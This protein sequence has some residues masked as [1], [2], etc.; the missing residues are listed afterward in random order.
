[1]NK[2]RIA[3]V[4]AS[5]AI[6]ALMAAGQMTAQAG[7]I[8]H[9]R[10]D[11]LYTS[12]AAS[13]AY[14][15]VGDMIINGDTRCSG[16]AISSTWILTAAHCVDGPISSLTFTVGSATYTGIDQIVHENWTTG[17]AAGWD[18]ALVRVGSAMSGITFASLYTGSDELGRVGT[19]VGFGRTGTGLTGSTLSSG[20]KRAGD[21]MI[22]VTGLAV[23]WS[24]NLLFQDFD[25][26]LNAGDSF[27]GLASPLNMEYL[28]APGDS[29]GGLFID[30][31][32][33]RYLAG[34]HSLIRWVDALGDSDYGDV[35][36]S[37]RVSSFVGWI[38]DK[39]NPIPEPGTL[40]LVGLGLLLLSGRTFARPS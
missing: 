39:I 31:G 37:T 40:A 27:F 25:N 5:A 13:A 14:S 6:L 23:G 20:T 28:I 15:G 21:N 1:M 33:T 24:D 19:N 7:V 29:G 10:A 38:N 30:V 16:T 32:G 11:S 2:T 9:D 36:G 34:V 4:R 26:P 35:A 8:R 12:L 18:I 3:R 17:L 22:D